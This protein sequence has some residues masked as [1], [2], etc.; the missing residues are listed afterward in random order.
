MIEKK[1]DFVVAHSTIAVKPQ[2]WAETYGP[3]ILSICI[4]AILITLIVTQVQE[5]SRPERSANIHINFRRMPLLEAAAGNMARDLIRVPVPAALVPISPPPNPPNAP[6]ATAQTQLGPKNI[7]GAVRPM[8][9]KPSTVEAGD[10]GKGDDIV[11]AGQEA[12]IRKILSGFGKGTT[13][14][15]Q[16]VNEGRKGIRQRLEVAGMQVAAYPHFPGYKGGRVGAVRTLNF[17]NVPAEVS[18]EVMARYNIRLTSGYVNPSGKNFLNSA[19]SG[20]SVYTTMDKPGYY[21]VFEIS[22]KACQQMVILEQ[23]WLVSHGYNTASTYVDVVEFGIVQKSTNFW[24]LGILKMEVQQLAE[25]GHPQISSSDQEP[26][27][28]EG[29]GKGASEG[30]TASASA[31]VPEPSAVSGATP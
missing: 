4:H 17:D 31:S 6:P 27:K 11:G 7:T 20:G 15:R 19:A 29:E 5:R 1:V 12:R 18:R 30:G 28:S 14:G 23:N 10:G 25:L 24:D 9:T 2:G 22:P 26:T 21:D 3:W 8:V 16:A 13:S